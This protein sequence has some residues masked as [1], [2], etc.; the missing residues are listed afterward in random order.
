MP[1]DLPLSGLLQAMIYE[2]GVKYP[3][4]M[5]M[6]LLNPV[7]SQRSECHIFQC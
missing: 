7:F 6:I 3:G 2:N 4:Q 5:S 1:P